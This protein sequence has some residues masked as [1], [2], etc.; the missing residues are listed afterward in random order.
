MTRAK[1]V[2]ISVVIKAGNK[3]T[4]FVVY[5]RANREGSKKGMPLIK[6]YPIIIKSMEKVARAENIT[7]PFINLLKL[8]HLPF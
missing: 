3:D 5:S 2:I 4:F 6:I 1:N 8:N 7:I